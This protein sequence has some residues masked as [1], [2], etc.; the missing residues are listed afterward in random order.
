MPAILKESLPNLLASPVYSQSYAPIEVTVGS[1]PPGLIVWSTPNSRTVCVWF[2]LRPH[3][4][5]S[6]ASYP[7]A[8]VESLYCPTIKGRLV[9]SV[10]VVR[11]GN[12]AGRVGHSQE[13][14]L[15]GNG[16]GTGTKPKPPMGF[17][18]RALILVRVGR[19]FHMQEH[20]DF[21]LVWGVGNDW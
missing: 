2:G 4:L 13:G 7:T 11:V 19:G 12:G 15:V 16:K 10:A 17:A 1:R 9:W 20:L 21:G 18:P 6:L 5:D 3:S 8:V 14:Q